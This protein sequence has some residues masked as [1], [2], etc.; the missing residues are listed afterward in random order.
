MSFKKTFLWVVGVGRKRVIATNFKW[1]SQSWWV[2]DRKIQACSSPPFPSLLSVGEWYL[3]CIHIVTKP[4]VSC[5]PIF[6]VII[7][8]GIL[9]GP[10]GLSTLFQAPFQRSHSRS[11]G[12]DNCNH[13][14]QWGSLLIGLATFSQWDSSVFSVSHPNPWHVSVPVSRLWEREREKRL[15]LLLLSEMS[16]AESWASIAYTN[17]NTICSASLWEVGPKCQY[18]NQTIHW[19]WFI[20]PEIEQCSSLVLRS[21]FKESGENKWLSGLIFSAGEQEGLVMMIVSGDNCREGWWW[22]AGAGMVQRLAGPCREG[23][24]GLVSRAGPCLRQ[25][26]SVSR[27]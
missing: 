15:I 2:W 23:P 9:S 3:Q 26:A 12:N 24:A 13:F 10:A 17:R 11:R 21:L 18:S 7:I 22:W 8:V 1:K 25:A 20:Y 16:A 27:S 19:L 6:V 14:A 5:F 4:L